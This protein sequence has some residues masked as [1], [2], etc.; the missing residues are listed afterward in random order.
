MSTDLDVDRLRE[1]L[2]TKRFG[3]DLLFEQEVSSTNDWAKRLARSG[4]A[5]G[6][7]VIAETQTAGR[8]RA[9]RTW[10]SPKGGLWFSIIL[11]PKLKPAEVIK[12]VFVASLAVVEVLRELY[13]LSVKTKWPNDV[14]IGGRKVCG[15]LSEMETMGDSVNFVV[16]GVGINAN[17]DV[18]VLPEGLRGVATSLEAELGGKVK[19]EE[20]FCALLEKLESIYYPFLKE[21]FAEVLRKWKRYANFLGRTVEVTYENERLI[22][23]AL[24]VED[25]GS[26]ILKLENGTR[27]RIFVGDV[28]LRLRRI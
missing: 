28:A 26:L 4:A 23:T 22:G 19:L 9:G 3:R 18:K 2:R 12:L 20:L 25:D 15:I 1:G 16:I 8:G 24:N 6:T 27:K 21:G 13:G 10:I 7:V 17:I 5:E 14:L 11:R